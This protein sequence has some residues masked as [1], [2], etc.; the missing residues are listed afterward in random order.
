M[1]II[2]ELVD[3]GLQSNEHRHAI[4]LSGS[5]QVIDEEIR[6]ADFSFASCLNG[7]RDWFIILAKA[8]FL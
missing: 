3:H 2:E 5:Y 1:I 8:A 6:R 7:D 4:R